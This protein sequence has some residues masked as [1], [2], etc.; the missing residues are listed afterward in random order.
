MYTGHNCSLMALF[1]YV[2]LWVVD[3]S[4]IMSA[5]LITMSK[6]SIQYIFGN[7]RWD[8]LVCARIEMY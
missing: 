3:K 6:T 7:I 1:K 4:H 2:A 8:N 5:T